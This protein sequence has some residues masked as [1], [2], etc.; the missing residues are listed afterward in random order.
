[1][2]SGNERSSLFLLC[3]NDEEREFYSFEARQMW[4]GVEA[5]ALFCLILKGRAPPQTQSK[6][7]PG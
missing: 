1:M 5:R 7:G 3:V 6:N 2:N 4:A